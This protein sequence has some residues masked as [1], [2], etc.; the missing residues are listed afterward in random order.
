MAWFD[1]NNRLICPCCQ[2][3]E[4]VVLEWSDSDNIH[5]EHEDVFMCD[6]C[7][8]VFEAVYKVTDIIIIGEGEKI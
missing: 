7:K 3:S 6:S 5:D 8:C 4:S 1:K 2:K